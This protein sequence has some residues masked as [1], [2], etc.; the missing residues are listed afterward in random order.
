[1]CRVNGVLRRELI[2][3]NRE[4]RIYIAQ[5]VFFLMIF[6][7]TC[8]CID[9]TWLRVLLVTGFIA[10]FFIMPFKE[11]W[12]KE[13]GYWFRSEKR[14]NRGVAKEKPGEEDSENEARV[15]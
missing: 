13:I 14:I 4:L 10:M 5:F 12:K 11:S 6:A 3:S 15:K 2:V 8:N 1:M 9:K 7:L